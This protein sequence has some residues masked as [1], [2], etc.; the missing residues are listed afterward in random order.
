MATQLKLQHQAENPFDIAKQQLREACIALG[1]DRGVY[2][3]LREPPHVFSVAIP[4]KMDSGEIKTF[5]G[6]RVQHT[7][8]TGPQR[9]AS[10]FTPISP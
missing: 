8:A 5:I 2:E 7:D 4:V 3:I 6:Y 1:L 9:E 10:G